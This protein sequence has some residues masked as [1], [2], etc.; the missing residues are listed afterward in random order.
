VENFLDLVQSVCRETVGL[1]LEAFL[2]RFCVATNVSKCPVPGAFEDQGLQAASELLVFVWPEDKSTCRSILETLGEYSMPME[3]IEQAIL[4][5]LAKSRSHYFES[6][7]SG[8][9]TFM[10]SQNQYLLTLACV[11]I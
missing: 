6:I 8:E 10:N 2:K 3:G 11:Q 7:R 5:I 4:Q 1:E 9:S